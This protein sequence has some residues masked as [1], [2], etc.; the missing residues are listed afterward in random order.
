MKII[1]LPVETQARLGLNTKI[2]L[3][4]TDLNG[5]GVLAAGNTPFSAAW[6]SGTAQAIEPVTLAA[7]VATLGGTTATLPAGTRVGGTVIN[8]VTPF[9][10]SGGAITSLGLTLGD[11]G[12]ATRFLQSV[13]LKTAGYTHTTAATYVEAAAFQI[14]ATATIVGQTI[15]S[16]NAGQIEIYCNIA[17]VLDLTAVK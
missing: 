7:G 9:T 4:Y 13:D 2:V 12:S 15:A 14:Q 8:V 3:D 1:P 17:P 6:T 5:A 16:L 11:A 10:S